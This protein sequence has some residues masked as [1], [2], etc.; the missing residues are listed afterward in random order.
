MKKGLHPPWGQH[1]Q[2]S[3][4]SSTSKAR[5]AILTCGPHG[6]PAVTSD[7]R[8]ASGGWGCASAVWGRS[9]PWT[10]QSCCQQQGQLFQGQTWGRSGCAWPPGLSGEDVFPRGSQ[11]LGGTPGV[12]KQGWP[13]QVPDEGHHKR[14]GS[15]PGEAGDRGPGLNEEWAPSLQPLTQVC[16]RG[17]V[18][19]ERGEWQ[20]HLLKNWH[21]PCLAQVYPGQLSL[22]GTPDPT[23]S[24]RTSARPQNTDF[25]LDT[26]CPTLCPAT[27]TK[28][29][30]DKGKVTGDFREFG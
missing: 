26:H 28:R 15:D 18:T 22:G 17:V 24:F 11:R 14:R 21:L 9:T 20:K 5:E 2:D 13:F 25:Q 10:L 16:V 19:V 1:A 3:S 23:L 7:T 29:S 30:V 8:E 6:H 12:P 27:S 4:D